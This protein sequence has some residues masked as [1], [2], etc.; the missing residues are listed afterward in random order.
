MTLDCNGYA[1]SIL[2][3]QD[4]MDMCYLCGKRGVKLDRHE[5]YSG[6]RR[7]KS[8]RLGLWVMLC[9]DD[10]HE[11][12]YGV[13]QYAAKGY[14]LKEKAQQIAMEHYGWTKDDFRHE[15]GKSYF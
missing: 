12:R 6:S 10:C 1:P 3:P 2:Q 5:V 13:H 7:A 8:K 14:A 15:F 4:K 9:H 11:G